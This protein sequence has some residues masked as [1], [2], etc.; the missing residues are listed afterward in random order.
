MTRRQATDLLEIV[1][2]LTLAAVAGL[3]FGR[4]FFYAL[5]AWA[6]R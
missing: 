4:F 3:V 5:T 1:A 2:A 6:L